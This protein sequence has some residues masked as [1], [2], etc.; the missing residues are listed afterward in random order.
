M[1]LFL[2][3]QMGCSLVIQLHVQS[4]SQGLD[5][6]ITVANHSQQLFESF[7]I[8]HL[9]K[10]LKNVIRV[11]FGGLGPFHYFLLCCTWECKDEIT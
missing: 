10:A 8:V 9:Y 2:E 5:Q 3:L 11:E 6:R 1:V 7:A 4:W